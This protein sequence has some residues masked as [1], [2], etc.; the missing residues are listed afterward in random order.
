MK[1]AL[2]YDK[3]TTMGGAERILLA[4]SEIFP[5]APLFTSVYDEKNAY[6]AKVFKVKTSFLQKIPFAKHH[7]EYFNFLFPL[8]FESFSFDKYDMVISVTSAQ[9]KG[10]ITKPQT[11]H[12]CYCLTP[13]RYLWQQHD[14]YL[15]SR[16]FGVFTNL[17]QAVIGKIWLNLKKWDEIAKER[18]DFYFAIAN[19]VKN[20]LKNY[21][22]KSALVVYPPVDISTFTPPK[23]NEKEKNTSRLILN[24]PYYLIVSRLVPYKMIDLAIYAFNKLKLNLVII[25]RGMDEKK[26]KNIATGSI[27]FIT[28][29]LTDEELR[30]YYLYCQALIVPQ[31]EDFG[32]SILEAQS[33][34]KPVI[35]FKSGGALEIIKEGITGEF[36][37]PQSSDALA[38]AVEKFQSVNY[39][40]AS[41]RK[42]AEKFAKDDFKK[43][44]LKNLL[45][46]YNLYKEKIK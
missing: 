15:K 5:D 35:A 26:L 36:F 43:N 9:A 18:P 21:Y 10:I 17:I 44:F 19:E 39:N 24:K 23:D 16:N 42:Q 7:Q 20:R 41:C 2:V 31:E 27:S 11:F 38:K 28:K 30:Q 12:L 1:V 40:P 34:G 37:S 33:C 25:G 14:L 13:T 22:H 32:L 46:Q 8:A 4:L 45:E 3:L 6:F 29:K